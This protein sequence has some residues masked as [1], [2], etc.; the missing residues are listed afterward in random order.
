MLLY[1][2]DLSLGTGEPARGLFPVE[3]PFYSQHSSVACSSLFRLGAPQ[4]SLFCVSMSIGILVVQV[5]FR[6]PC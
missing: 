1:V 6:Q 5:L 3:D 4:A 2:Y